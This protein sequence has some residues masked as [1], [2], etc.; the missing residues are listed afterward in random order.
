MKRT[1]QFFWHIIHDTLMEE[2][3][4]WSLGVTF[5]PFLVFTMFYAYIFF[6]THLLQRYVQKASCLIFI[7]VNKTMNMHPS[8]SSTVSQKALN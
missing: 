4:A 3:F 8:S 5:L 6:T 7:I 1:I 2:I